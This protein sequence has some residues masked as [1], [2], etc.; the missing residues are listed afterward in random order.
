MDKY[1][2]MSQKEVKKY[3]IITKLISKEL[4][5]SEAAKLLSLTRRHVRRLKKKVRQNGMKGLIHGNRGK[6]GN[7]SMPD[8]EK[9]KIIDLLHKR[10][11]DFGPTLASEKLA[12]RHQIKRD[13]GTVR[14]IMISEG[15]WKPNSKKKEKH[16]QWRQRKASYGEMVQYDGS[17]EH[18]F[19]DRGGES[20]LLA[21]VDDATGKVWAKLDE[22]EGIEPTFSFCVNI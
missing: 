19:E 9:Q 3:D 1:I 7:R 8:K 12:E 14:T 13:K 17:Y 4:N 6:P 22:H 16:R 11:C 15:L 18:W 20:C 10:Y 21:S 5:G 2:T